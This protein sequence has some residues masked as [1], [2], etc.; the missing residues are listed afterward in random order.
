MRGFLSGLPQRRS[1]GPFPSAGFARQHRLVTYCSAE[2]VPGA[3]MQLRPHMH[4][5]RAPDSSPQLWA[6]VPPF[7]LCI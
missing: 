7:S 4:A 6:S 2:A 5:L 3:L 1:M